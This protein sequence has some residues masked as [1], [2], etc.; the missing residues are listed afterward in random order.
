MPFIARLRTIK[1]F[2]RPCGWDAGAG[3]EAAGGGERDF[4][5]RADGNDAGEKL[6]EVR[7]EAFVGELK[8]GGFGKASHGLADAAQHRRQI[9]GQLGRGLSFGLH[10]STLLELTA[11]EGA[12]S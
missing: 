4:V 11:V 8:E 2:E 12:A 6:L 9:Q 1:H 5:E 10:G 7:G 3:E